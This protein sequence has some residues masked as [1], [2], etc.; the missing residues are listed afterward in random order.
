MTQ[1]SGNSGPSSRGARVFGEI[2]READRG[3]IEYARRNVN[4]DISSHHPEDLRVLD[5]LL[6]EYFLKAVPR[7]SDRE[8][9]S[10]SVGSYLG[11][12][13]VRN[14]GGRWHY[15]RDFQAWL[16]Y[17]EWVWWKRGGVLRAERYCYVLVSEHRI[18]VCRAAREAVTKTG[19]VFPLYDFY[20]QWAKATGEA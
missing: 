7:K 11:E 9:A 15:P 12:V 2:L 17:F 8:Q 14:L 18:D 20:Q 13:F 6:D 1:P 16:V 10:F 3:A 5:D 19:L 4:A